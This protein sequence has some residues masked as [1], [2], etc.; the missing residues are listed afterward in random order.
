MK[1]TLMLGLALGF[2]SA[3]TLGAFANESVKSDSVK[4]A[5]FK[6]MCLRNKNTL[7]FEEGQWTCIST[8]ETDEGLTSIPLHLPK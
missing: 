1:Y 7:K 8:K 4:L 2:L 3:I 6:G 5:E